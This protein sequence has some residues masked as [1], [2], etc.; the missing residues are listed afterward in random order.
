M[1]RRTRSARFSRRL[2]PPRSCSATTARGADY[3]KPI[4]ERVVASLEKAGLVYVD[5]AGIQANPSADRSQEGVEIARAEGVDW[6]LPVG[7]G[8]VID[9]AKYIAVGYYYEGDMWE[10]LYAGNGKV[11]KALPVCTINTL[12]GTGSEGSNSSVMGK[13]VLK[14]SLNDDMIRPKIAIMDP[15]LAFTLPPF[16]TASAAVDIMAHAH[17]RYFT[18]TDD[19]FLTDGL[20][21]AVIKTV[22]KYLPIALED[23]TNYEAL[24][25]AP[26]GER[27]RAQRL[28]RRRPWLRGRHRA[29]H[30]VRD[31]RHV[32]LRSRRRLRVR[33]ARVDELRVERASQPLRALL[34][35]G[36]GASRTTRSTRRA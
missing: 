21:E 32:P 6:M 31:R 30:R 2:A 36:L 22:I 16:Q 24:C 26:L 18:I 28:L 11:E 13:G 12:P 29:R 20:G 5:F 8:S 3:E 23:P 34:R 9:T 27:A 33:D 14:R 15:E 7:G 4:I 17:E 10:D 19:N 1:E 25:A 35:E